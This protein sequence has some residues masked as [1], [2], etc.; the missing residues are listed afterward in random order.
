MSKYKLLIVGAFP[1]EDSSI[2]GGILTSCRLLMASDLP[3]YFD[4]VLIDSTQKSNPAPRY[5]I[6][7]FFAIQRTLGYF[8]ALLREKPDAVLLF[9]SVGASVVEKGTMAWLARSKKRPVF[10]FPQGGLL[11]DDFRNKSWQRRWILP[12]M[13][14]ATHILCQGPAWQAFAIKDLGYTEKNAPIIYNWSATTD[15]L[16]LGAAR[17]LH[18]DKPKLKILFLGWLEQ[19]KGIFELLEACRRLW[20]ENSFLLTIAGSGNAEKKVR[21]LVAE[22][23]MDAY[24][25]LEGWVHNE[26]KI[27][28][29]NSADI[30]VLPSWAEGFP[31]AIIEA[32][33]A[34]VAVIVSAVGNVPDMLQHRKQA[35][36]VPPKD[37]NALI[38]A[39]N[40]LFVNP[41]LRMEI[42]ER[43]FDYA[44]ENLSTQKGVERLAGIVKAAIEHYKE[45]R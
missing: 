38:D 19:E 28:L 16:R 2:I 36:I 3:N 42:A 15:L 37:V 44:R 17:V 32:M 13:K 27:N 4:L 29:L 5:V 26:Q 34:K 8:S 7:L 24:V 33:A 45:L 11:I 6:R 43:G 30:L 35:M 25:S 1:S 20:A 39:L 31:N 22:H 14:G 40:E 41:S 10:L 21:D 23:D 9:T 18:I 12:M